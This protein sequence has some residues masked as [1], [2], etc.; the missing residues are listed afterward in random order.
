MEYDFSDPKI[1]QAFL[2]FSMV[3]QRV[4]EAILVGLM[5]REIARDP[6]AG[7]ELTHMLQELLKATS[8]IEMA[9]AL[10]RD[11]LANLGR[12]TPSA[13]FQRISGTAVN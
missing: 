12:E 4:L 9:A 11:L 1:V 8:P 3:R 13:Y 6:D 5:N 7:K 2:E 10:P